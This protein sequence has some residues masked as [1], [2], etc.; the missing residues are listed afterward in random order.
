MLD[1]MLEAVQIL[2]FDWRYLY[3]NNAAARNGRQVKEEMLGRTV[4]ERYPGFETTELFA[5]PSAG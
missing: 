4:M 3:V 2:G 1:N 5:S